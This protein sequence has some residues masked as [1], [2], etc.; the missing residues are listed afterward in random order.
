MATRINGRQPH[1]RYFG[2]N[3]LPFANEWVVPRTLELQAPTPCYQSISQRQTI[4]YPHPIRPYPAPILLRD[5]RLLYRRE[6]DNSRN[7]ATKFITLAYRPR[8]ALKRN[9]PIQSRISI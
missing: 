6:K 3:E 2:Q 9:M 4:F 5:T 8:F 1:I 7:F